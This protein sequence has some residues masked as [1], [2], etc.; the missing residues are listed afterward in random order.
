MTKWQKIL[1]SVAAGLTAVSAVVPV[2]NIVTAP[3][4]VSLGQ[5]LFAAGVFAAGV[6]KATP[7]H[8]PAPEVK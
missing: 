1:L 5:A 3:V 7:G 8:V 4:A 6:A 2:I